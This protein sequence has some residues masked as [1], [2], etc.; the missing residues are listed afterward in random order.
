MSVWDNR[1]CFFKLLDFFQAGSRQLIHLWTLR[2]NLRGRGRQAL[3]DH[4]NK[5]NMYRYLILICAVTMQMCLGA[6]YSWSVYVNPLKQ[7]TGLGQGVVQIPFTVF[8]FMFP[9]TMVFIGKML[10]QAGVRQCAMIGGVVFGSGWIL[11]GLGYSHFILTILGIGLFAGIG[12]GFAYMVPIATAVLWF[13][14]Q[15]GLV[16]GIAVAGFGGG[17]ALVS[18]IGGYLMN[19]QQYNPY[20]VFTIFGISFFVI[21][22]IAGFFMKVPP[23]FSYSPASALRTRKIIFDKTFILLYLCMFTALSAGFTINANLK[24]LNLNIAIENGILAVSLFA[25][26]NAAG[27]IFWGM[28]CDKIKPMLAIALNL[29]SQ[30]ALLIIGLMIL[31]DVSG[32]LL[33]A[34]LSGFNYGGVLVIYAST[35]TRKWG[36]ENVGQVYGWLFSANIPAALAPVAAGLVFDSTGSFTIPLLALAIALGLVTL[37]VTRLKNFAVG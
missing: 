20:E 21:V 33:F 3:H 16:T 28:L 19:V 17:A 32:F 4:S 2:H 30:A 15:K 6:T 37:L 27:R 13:P 18:Q 22:S 34:S 24:E 1:N 8:Y 25:I 29:A 23:D 12:V 35:V 5:S 36:A 10:H 11:A 14:N 7:L 31:K 26:A 9:A